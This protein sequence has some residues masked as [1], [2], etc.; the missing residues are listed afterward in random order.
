[1]YIIYVVNLSISFN[2]GFLQYFSF[3]QCTFPVKI[4]LEILNINYKKQP[5]EALLPAPKPPRRAA[6]T[7]NRRSTA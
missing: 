3:Y 7:K 5:Y 4:N 6:A 1:M 2:K